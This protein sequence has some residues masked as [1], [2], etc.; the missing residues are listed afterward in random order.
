M[1]PVRTHNENRALVCLMCF[2]KG[3]SMRKITG[4][5]LSRIQKYFIED[6]ATSTLELPSSICS[7]CRKILINVE[8]GKL[9]I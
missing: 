8:N 7:R 6:F 4:V 9:I 2:E 3:S 5:I 1:P